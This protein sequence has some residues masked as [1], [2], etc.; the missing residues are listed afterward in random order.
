M[1]RAVAIAAV[2][3]ASVA[4]V[5]AEDVTI[6]TVDQCNETAATLDGLLADTAVTGDSLDQA[7]EAV[8]NLK[9]ACESGDLETASNAATVAQGIL[10]AD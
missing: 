6:S 4:V 9:A 2:L 10:K 1:I 8:D 5:H 7:K 3:V